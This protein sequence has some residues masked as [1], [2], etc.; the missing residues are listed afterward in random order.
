MRRQS[1]PLTGPHSLFF[2]P[3]Q[4]A[5]K[6]TS[7]KHPTCSPIHTW[8]VKGV[9]EPQFT[10][11]SCNGAHSNRFC[12]QSAFIC[13]VFESFFA[14]PRWRK[15]AA[16]HLSACLLSILSAVTYYSLYLQ[17]K[18]LWP[19]FGKIA[20][21]L[22]KKSQQRPDYLTV[23]KCYLAQI[24]VWGESG[25]ILTRKTVRTASVLKSKIDS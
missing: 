24:L 10:W 12:Q 25:V 17:S 14:F 19:I 6:Q 18:I 16:L 13:P 15:Q 8:V 9:A 7:G 4:A 5:L 1:A 23:L 2:S 20:P 3:H 11:D 21:S 22:L